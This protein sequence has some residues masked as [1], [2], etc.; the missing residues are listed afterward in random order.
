[1]QG[2]ELR[3]YKK[4]KLLTFKNSISW[5]LELD[6]TSIQGRFEKG[7]M[8][9]YGHDHRS[10]TQLAWEQMDIWREYW[11]WWDTCFQLSLKVWHS[12]IQVIKEDVKHCGPQYWSL[13]GTT[14]DWPPAGLCAVDANPLGL[15][16]QPV[17]NPL[18]C[19]LW[20]SPHF[21]RLSIRMVQE[22]LSKALLK[23]R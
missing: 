3:L 15:T 1:M 13:P 22:T 23:S 10:G 4:P 5:I 16:V 9:L 19:S 7:G 14:N 8:G 12:I 20:H 17:L 18:H 2:A 21:I 11:E 6:F